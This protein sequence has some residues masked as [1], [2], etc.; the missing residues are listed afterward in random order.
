MKLVYE[1]EFGAF[2]GVSAAFLKKFVPREVNPNFEVYDSVNG[3]NRFIAVKSSRIPDDED[4]AAGRIGIDFNRAKPTLKEALQYGAELPRGYKWTGNIAFAST[5]KEEYDKKSSIWDKFYSYIWDS[6][7]QTVWVTPHSG[8]VNIPPDDIRAFPKLMIDNNTAEVAALCAFND[9]NKAMKRIMIAVHST[10]QLGALINLGDLGVVDQEKMNLVAKKIEMKYHEKAQ[11]LAD[12]F[13]QEF[14][15]KTSRILEHIKAHRGTLNPE[16]LY[17]IRRDDGFTIEL[18]IKCLKLYGQEIKEFTLSEFNEALRNLG[19]I[20]VPV[21]SNNFLYTGRNVGMLL[22]LPEMIKNGQLHS[23]LLIECARVY[24][25]RAPGL[26]AD[27]ILDVK[28]G[29]FG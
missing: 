20:D 3:Y 12:E 29:L 17:Q 9:S 16:E 4:L 26:M 19:K 11:V 1:D 22:K 2:S 15:D 21:V 25:L 27:I 10:G 8:S 14:C 18:Y 7:L 23:A 6:T 28:T 5:N 24:M 13:K